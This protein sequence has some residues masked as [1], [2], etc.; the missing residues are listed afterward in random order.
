[1]TQDQR[2]A[3]LDYLEDNTTTLTSSATLYA[4]LLAALQAQT[5]AS[6]GVSQIGTVIRTGADGAFTEF[7]QASEYD[8]GPQG[9]TSEWAVIRRTYRQARERLIN[10][11]IDSLVLTDREV[12]D[13]M[14][15]LLIPVR[16]FGASYCAVGYP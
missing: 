7:A 16:E 2:D 15:F 11:G 12:F 6:V 3:F 9:R 10:S 14:R 4:T 13:E 1:M 8:P 5:A